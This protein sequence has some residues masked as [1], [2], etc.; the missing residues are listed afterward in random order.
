MGVVQGHG[1]A[2]SSLTF[3]P[4]G[5]W[6]VSGSLDST[7]RLWSLEDQG[8]TIIPLFI[9]G[10]HTGSVNSV[11]FSPKGALIAS[12]SSDSTVRLWEIPEEE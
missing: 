4:D 12:G 10:G 1:D 5:Q 11:E 3:S 6:M 7:I 8:A 2:V 9:L